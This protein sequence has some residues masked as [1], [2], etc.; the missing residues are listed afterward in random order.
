M[1]ESVLLVPVAVIAAIP[2]DAG[3]LP[4]GPWRT[5]NAVVRGDLR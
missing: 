4:G 1:E 3:P 2:R 5:T